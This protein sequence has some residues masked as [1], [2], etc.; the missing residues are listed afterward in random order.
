ML[1]SFV[2]DYAVKVLYLSVFNN[3]GSNV[4]LL[5]LLSIFFD[6]ATRTLTRILTLIVCMG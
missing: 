1:V 6:S 3:T 2:I 5:S 4:F